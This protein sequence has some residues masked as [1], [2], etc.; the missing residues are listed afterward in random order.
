MA[1]LFLRIS[2]WFESADKDTT[3]SF[4][5]ENSLP[6]TQSIYPCNAAKILAWNVT[7]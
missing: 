4:V 1:G 2:S 5:A 7:D 3:S 6:H